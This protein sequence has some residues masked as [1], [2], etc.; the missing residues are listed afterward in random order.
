MK[1][2]KLLL[3]ITLVV[4]LFASCSKPQDHVDMSELKTLKD[5]ASYALGY[6]NGLQ[7][8]QTPEA[9]VN[10][11]LYAKAFKQGYNKDTAG[12]WNETMMRSVIMEYA[13]KAQEQMQAKALE[14]AKPDLD[15]AEK[16][17]EEN[18]KKQGVHT[19]NS[20][21]QYKVI[22][23]GKG[24]K[25]VLN[26]GDRVIIYYARYVLNEKGEMEQ[27]V[28]TF[29]ADG[30]NPGPVGI[31]GQIEGIKEVLQLMNAGSRYQ[32]WIHP[33][34]GYG[35]SPKLEMYEIEVLKVLHEV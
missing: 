28:N 7:A 9:A 11:D 33:N 5:S 6:L 16:F 19:T 25:P 27:V 23:S 1:S 4:L 22:K 10:V 14:Q 35:D 32:V 26:S 21:L 3:S 20:G 31:D 17:L 29:N 2:I 15:R 24:I 34:L 13:R 18:G 30:K 8:A 12:A